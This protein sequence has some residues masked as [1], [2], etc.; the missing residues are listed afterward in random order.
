MFFDIDCSDPAIQKK[1]L[2]SIMQTCKK[3]GIGNVFVLSAKQ[4]LPFQVGRDI[5]PVRL[6]FDSGATEFTSEALADHFVIGK[7]VGQKSLQLMQYYC[8]RTPGST[9]QESK[10]SRTCV[11]VL[12]EPEVVL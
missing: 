12:D 9:I 8:E 7:E 3:L 6:L 10:V 4:N 5:A 1:L 2:F 11:F